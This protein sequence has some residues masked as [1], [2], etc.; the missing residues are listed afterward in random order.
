MASDFYSIRQQDFVQVKLNLNPAG[1]PLF[2]Y[3]ADKPCALVWFQ[4]VD[5][6]RPDKP[7]KHFRLVVNG[8]VSDLDADW[9]APGVLVTPQAAL[10]LCRAYPGVLGMAF[11]LSQGLNLSMLDIDRHETNANEYTRWFADGYYNEPTSNDGMHYFCVGR[12]GRN[13]T[14]PVEFYSGDH[15]ATA[16]FFGQGQLKQNYDALEHF[17]S[18]SITY[19]IELFRPVLTHDNRAA[20]DILQQVQMY[21]PALFNEVYMTLHRQNDPLYD[22]SAMDM[23]LI[24]SIMD[25]TRDPDLI[26]QVFLATGFGQRLINRQ[27]GEKKKGKNYLANSIRKALPRQAMFW[28]AQD[29]REQN[30]ALFNDPN[31][32]PSRYAQLAPAPDPE[33]ETPASIVTVAVPEP[34]SKGPLYPDLPKGGMF[35]VV[36]DMMFYGY[37][38]ENY[39]FAKM[40]ALDTVNSLLMPFYLFNGRT[41]SNMFKVMTGPTS[42]GKGMVLKSGTYLRMINTIV[43]ET[44]RGHKQPFVDVASTP[45]RERYVTGPMQGSVR[46]LDKLYE[47]AV[48]KRPV[49]AIKENDFTQSLEAFFMDIAMATGPARNL[50]ELGDECTDLF[51]KSE[52]GGFLETK[53]T[54]KSDSINIFEPMIDI[55]FEGTQEPLLTAIAPD[56]S[57]LAS[58]RVNRW[59]FFINDEYYPAKQR[60]L[61]E[62]GDI[63]FRAIVNNYLTP[64]MLNLVRRTE[65]CDEP[66]NYTVTPEISDHE[67]QAYK[68]ML[69]DRRAFDLPQGARDTYARVRVNVQKLAMLFAMERHA[70]GLSQWFTITPDDIDLA[71][72]FVLPGYDYIANN[73]AAGNVGSTEETDYVYNGA[74]LIRAE[75]KKFYGTNAYENWLTSLGNEAQAMRFRK[76]GVVPFKP[77]REKIWSNG[78]F[79]SK[80]LRQNKP[81]AMN[82]CL[83]YLQDNEYVLLDRGTAEKNAAHAGLCAAN[84]LR[85]QGEPITNALRVRVFK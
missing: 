7:K 67:I 9:R 31:F 38:V 2:D 63:N 10:E 52:P 61:L 57:N 20:S 19:D 64:I 76:L 12:L 23:K 62:M 84:G 39:H 73:F 42:A 77:V 35:S 45:L 30:P 47:K 75:L 82:A 15:L 24:M 28:I 70:S 54:G 40:H 81:A 25:Y 21:E 3:L 65:N 11:V 41:R 17:D 55:T 4:V 37:S 85:Q 53:A 80:R 71:Y 58:G 34:K 44:M 51:D 1:N 74:M 16:S 18:I 8:R 43:D 32:F 50:A 66:I 26:Y 48:K 6:S 29:F 13:M 14:K 33:P 83:E 49:I 22:A 36:Q 78:I 72:R 46:G 5:P 60:A 59:I 27:P 79:N 69:V 68:R 56:G